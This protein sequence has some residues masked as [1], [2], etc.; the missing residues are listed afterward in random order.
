MAREKKPGPKKPLHVDTLT[1]V[2]GALA[3]MSLL[4]FI[5]ISLRSDHPSGD[6]LLGICSAIVLYLIGGRGPSMLEKREGR[7]LRSRQ[8]R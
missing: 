3:A 7:T 8:G 4:G 1:L 5:V 2:L 6:A